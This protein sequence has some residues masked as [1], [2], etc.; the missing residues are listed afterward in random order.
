MG[1]RDSILEWGN[2]VEGETTDRSLRLR[3]RV[4]ASRGRI[5]DVEEGKR[6]RRTTS[7]GSEDEG[8]G[9]S[10]GIKMGRAF[11]RVSLML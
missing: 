8:K 11:C 9:S 7:D 1:K 4:E 6:R 3:R 10:S 5:D 2:V